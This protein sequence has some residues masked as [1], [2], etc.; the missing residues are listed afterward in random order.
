[1]THPFD[2]IKTRQQAFMYDRPG[3]LT[4]TDSVR[5][6]YK[7]NGYSVFWKGV[8]PRC[9]RIIC[10]VIILNETKSNAVTYLEKSNK[11]QIVLIEK[12]KRREHNW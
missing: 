12:E 7:E 8:M 9:F 4:V 11:D 6:M 5:Q 10:A 3:Y 1:M 2:T